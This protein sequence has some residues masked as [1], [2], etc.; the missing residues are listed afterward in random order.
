MHATKPLVIVKNQTGKKN[1]GLRKRIRNH[2]GT[3]SNVAITEDTDI[4]VGAAKGG[5][6][7]GGTV[8]VD[9]KGF[10]SGN[11]NNPCHAMLPDDYPSIL[12]RSAVL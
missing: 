12:I 3:G 4:Q 6:I 7:C 11:E 10:K 8:E 5:A 2:I 9:V 1:V